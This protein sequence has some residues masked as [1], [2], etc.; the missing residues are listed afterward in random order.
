MTAET[1]TFD[2]DAPCGST[3]TYRD[4]IECGKT[5]GEAAERGRQIDNVPRNVG[6]WR[7]LD[8][9]CR[10]V[11]DPLA[12]AF[13]RPELTYGFASRSLA[14]NIRSGIAPRLDQHASHEQDRSGRPV[15]AR[16]GAAVD[17]CVPGTSSDEVARWIFAKTRFDRLYLYGDGRPL[18]VS[19]GPENRR[20][21]L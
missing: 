18:H 12:R 19:V 16:L 4:L 15:C 20:S 13:G 2:L 10:V 8:E 1:F 9:L 21:V 3:F 6:T 11:V 14:S 17:L 5:W 7:A